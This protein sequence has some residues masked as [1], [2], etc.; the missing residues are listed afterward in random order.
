MLSERSL[1]AW[2]HLYEVLQQAK[3]ISER[4]HWL[5]MGREGLRRKEHD[6]TFW[7][8]GNVLHLDTGLG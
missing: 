7:G 6:R 5:P 2:F 4:K 3:L 1:T 8:D